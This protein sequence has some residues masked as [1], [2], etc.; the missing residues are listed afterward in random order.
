MHPLIIASDLDRT[1]LHI[2]QAEA[3]E[4]FQIIEDYCN[5][6]TPGQVRD[7]FSELVR[8]ALMNDD[9]FNLMGARTD[10]MIWA[11]HTEK[12][13]ETSYAIQALLEKN[14]TL[15]KQLFRCVHP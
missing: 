14:P 10:L 12:L 13:L 1:L 8:T 9:H 3:E 4:P 5:E 2:T 6:Y 11:E 15:T 7:Y